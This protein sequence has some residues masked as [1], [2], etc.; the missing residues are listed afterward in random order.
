MTTVIVAAHN[1]EAVI[2]ACLDALQ[3]EAERGG[4]EVIVSANACSDDTARVARERGTIVVERTE[5]GKASAIN[6]AERIASSFPRIYLDADIVVPDGG[7]AR[8]VE[9]LAT[10]PAPLAVVPRRRVVVDGRPWAVRAYFAV[11]ERLPV[12]S[13]GLFGRG[14]IAVSERGRARFDEFP[15]LLADDLFLDSQFA[16]A[17]KAQVADVEVNV[18]APYTTADLLRRLV[19]VRRGNAQLRAAAADGR[20]STEVRASARW[21]WLGVVLRRPW[22]APHGIAYAIITVI[23]ARGARSHDG[24][25]WGRDE[26]TRRIEE[27][28]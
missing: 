14:M 28:R 18:E 20:I 25:T 9:L 8:V 23:A 22:L 6:A 26:S 5:P 15:A 27:G 16:D 11:N 4:I 7:V 1:E 21:A 17:E 12:F 13:K 10:D 19:R 3:R 24:E 2:G